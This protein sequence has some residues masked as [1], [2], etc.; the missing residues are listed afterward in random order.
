MKGINRSVDRLGRIVLP[1][2]YRK[3][4]NISENS[5]VSIILDDNKI[6]ISPQISTCAICGSSKNLH[7]EL[8]LCQ[9]CI[10]SIK[11]ST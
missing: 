3:H 10:I 1:K 11:K 9:D 2:D 8:P 5:V 4:L 6:I 7:A